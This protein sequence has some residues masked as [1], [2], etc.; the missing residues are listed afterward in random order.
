MGKRDRHICECYNSHLAHIVYECDKFWW[1]QPNYNLTAH[2][3]VCVCVWASPLPASNWRGCESNPTVAVAAPSPPAHRKTNT[4]ILLFVVLVQGAPSITKPFPCRQQAKTCL[5]IILQ[6]KMRVWGE[7]QSSSI[8]ILLINR[9]N[10]R[11]ELFQLPCCK[12]P[13][14][15]CG[16]CSVSQA[17][18][19]R[20]VNISPCHLPQM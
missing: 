4:A 6:R 13:F 11:R 15:V 8:Y 5:L 17:R 7:A 20:C 3:F 10:G 9:E 18:P 12:Y 2:M 14:W 16:M 19:I 1:F